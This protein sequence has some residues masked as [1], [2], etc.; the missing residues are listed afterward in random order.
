MTER[1]WQLFDS[2]PVSLAQEPQA[3]PA[4]QGWTLNDSFPVSLAQTFSAL[5]AEWS[6]AY[7]GLFEPAFNAAQSGGAVYTYVASGGATSSGAAAVAKVK[8]PAVSGGTQSSG[9][10]PVAK[11]KNF[12]AAGGAVSGGAAGLAKTTAIIAIGGAVVGGAA[13]FAKIKIYAGAGGAQTAG[14]AL[15]Q[16]ISGG[17][18]QEFVYIASGG[19]AI[20]GAAQTIYESAAVSLPSGDG[21]TW[22]RLSAEPLPRTRGYAARGGLH[23]GGR[24]QSGF[25]AGPEV[26]IYDYTAT[27]GARAGGAA[28]IL[29]MDAGKIRRRR[30]AELL[31]L[32]EAA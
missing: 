7:W 4:E 29:Y 30:Q 28:E 6:A 3:A 17:A 16:F 31:L 15:T 23:A 1:N 14:A 18:A 5:Q 24:A 13:D 12:V 19:A 8:V 26:D 27:G 21:R 9:L 11:T 10:A 2:F 22:R 20:S 32:L 25:I